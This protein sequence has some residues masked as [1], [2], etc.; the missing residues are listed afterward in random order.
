MDHTDLIARAYR[1]ERTGWGWTIALAFLMVGA[2]ASCDPIEDDGP[3]LGALAAEP[4]IRVEPVADD[5]NFVVIEDLSE[6]FFSRVWELPG[7]TPSTSTERLDTVLYTKAGQYEV[8]FYAS[9]TDG[10]GTATTSRGVAIA[11]DAVVQCNEAITLLAGGCDPGTEK[12]WTFSRAEGAVKVGPVPGSGE[13]FTSTEDGL[14]AEQY[15]DAFCFAFEGASFRYLNQGLTVD[16]EQGF[17]PVPYEPLVDQ[18]FQLL[19][20]AGEEGETRIQLPDGNFIG[21]LNGDTFYDIITLTETDLV[22]R[23]N[24]IGEDNWF[25]LVFVAL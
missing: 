24:I 16:P 20:G 25:E 19:P 7:A 10:G 17:S 21:L 12:C 2:F 15:D 11:E 9:A 18:T 8:R 22:L 6:G 1:A 23:T 14:Q 5:P 3:G 13:F 4:S